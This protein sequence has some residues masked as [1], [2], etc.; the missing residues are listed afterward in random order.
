VLVSILCMYSVMMITCV[1]ACWKP[2]SDGFCVQMQEAAAETMDVDDDIS[3]D[4]A[5]MLISVFQPA[6][7]SQ[8]PSSF[9]A[10]AMASSSSDKQHLSSIKCMA[11]T[12]A[13]AM[14]SASSAT[15]ATH[16]CPSLQ[17]VQWSDELAVATLTG[18][19]AVAEL[20]AVDFF[21]ADAEDTEADAS[22]LARIRHHV[23]HVLSLPTQP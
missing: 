8:P 14:M 3:S 19:Q 11:N 5:E 17:S 22:A 12:Y 13:R 21:V 1:N 2:F 20:L 16:A 9:A 15:E 23:Q 4:S 10:A 18:M 6:S 7:D